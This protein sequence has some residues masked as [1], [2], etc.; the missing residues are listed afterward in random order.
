MTVDPEVYGV[1]PYSIN[2]TSGIGS[3]M[4]KSACSKNA[5]EGPVPAGQYHID[6]SQISNPG[7]VRDLLRNFGGGGDWGD[8]RVPVIPDPGTNTFDRSGFF[9]HGGAKLG[10]RGCI[11]VGGGTFGDPTTDR[12]LRDLQNDPDGRV[13]VN[14]R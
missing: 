8:W 6:V 4:N 3:C 11:D 9:L 13:P 2:I 5:N 1:L 7:W 10:T 12:L 14:V